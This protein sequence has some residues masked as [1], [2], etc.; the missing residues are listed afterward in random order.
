MATTTKTTTSTITSRTNAHPVRAWAEAAVWAYAGVV[1]DVVSLAVQAPRKLPD[2][3]QELSTKV[4]TGLDRTVSSV[5]ARLEAK[6]D[7]GRKAVED[8]RSRPEVERVTSSLQPLVDQAHNTRSQLKAAL[9][10]VTK[11]VNAATD[12]ASQQLQ[13]FAEQG[14]GALT[15]L[16]K[17]GDAA[18]EAARPQAANARS[19]VR[20]ARTSTRKT[21]DTAVDA[22]VDAGKDLAN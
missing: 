5:N 14:K 19:Q 6:A 10:S 7:D 8:L 13:T 21:V 3:P 16:G 4:R 12:G 15:S 22:A 17:V 18:S 20:A 9:T 11:T 1:N 2:S